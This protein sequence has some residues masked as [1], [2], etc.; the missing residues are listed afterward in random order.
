MLFYNTRREKNRHGR[1]GAWGR[2]G[3]V[4]GAAVIDGYVSAL[5]RPGQYAGSDK[6]LTRYFFYTHSIINNN[7]NNFK[8]NNV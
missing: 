6:H 5:I 1:G 3:G 4:L 2:Q 8:I 7:K